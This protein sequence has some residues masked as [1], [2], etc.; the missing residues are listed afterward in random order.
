[1]RPAGSSGLKHAMRQKVRKLV[2][3]FPTTT[4]AM[5]ME[6]SCKENAV[7][8]RLVSVPTGISASCGLC[9]ICLIEEADQVKTWLQTQKLPYENFYEMEMY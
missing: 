4:S 5:A 3:T 8:G 7:P 6:K 9:W 1:M 2:V